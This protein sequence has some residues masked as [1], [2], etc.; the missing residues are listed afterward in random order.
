MLGTLMI[1]IIFR[2]TPFVN[3][4]EKRDT[5][6]NDKWYKYYI[7]YTTTR[8]PILYFSK[9]EIAANVDIRA[10]NL[11]ARMIDYNPINRPSL[12]QVLADPF[13]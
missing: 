10:L 3:K 4:K 2:A 1:T 6:L 13:I 9:W 7:I 11:I 12:E 5:C 8:N